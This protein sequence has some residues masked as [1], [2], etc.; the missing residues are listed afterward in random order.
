MKTIITMILLLIDG[1]ATAGEQL[2]DVQHDSVRG[3]TCWILNN[4]GISCLPDSSLLQTPTGTA[5]D[6]SQAARASL[7]TSMC[8]SEQLHTTPRPPGKGFQL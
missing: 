1:Q 3:V 7:A 4:T 8:Q 5:A 2:I 6:E